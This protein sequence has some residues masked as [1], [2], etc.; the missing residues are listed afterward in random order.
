ACLANSRVNK[1]GTHRV[2][3]HRLVTGKP[4]QQVEEMNR[5]ITQLPPRTLD[6]R[7]RRR[8]R[9]ATRE[10]NDLYFADIAAVDGF[11]QRRM[12][13]IESAVATQHDWDFRR[14]HRSHRLLRF[15]I[16]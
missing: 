14:A 12:A 8:L 7:N 16:L 10:L 3:L 4:A 9:T 13:R 15:F 11:F 6:I 5:L 1:S 2:H